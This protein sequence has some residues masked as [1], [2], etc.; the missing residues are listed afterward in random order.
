MFFCQQTNQKTHFYCTT[1]EKPFQIVLCYNSHISP[2]FVQTIVSIIHIT[3]FICIISEFMRFL[4]SNHSF[5]YLA[6]ILLSASSHVSCI[7]SPYQFFPSP[8]NDWH[9]QKPHNG[10]SFYDTNPIS[11]DVHLLPTDHWNR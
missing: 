4:F 8:E 1:Y 5:I 6:E 2:Y 11:C 7:L 9:R 10:Y 3:Y